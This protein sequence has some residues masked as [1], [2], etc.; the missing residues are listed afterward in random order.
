MLRNY[1]KISIRNLW[2]HKLLTSLNIFGLSLSMS[3]CLV[4][5]L[6]VRDH[7]QYDKFHPY[8][9]STYRITT[10]TRG[11]EGLFDEGYATS[12][13]PFMEILTENYSFVKSGTNLNSSF[14]GEIRS[15][16][17]I[18]DVN[19][20]FADEHFFDVFG[21]ELIEGDPEQ[22]LKEP[23]SLV[24]S[25][26]MAKKLFPEQS[27]LG[28]T[29]DF[30]DH[31]SY[32][33]TG[34][35]GPVD[36][37]T[38][39]KFEGLAS[40]STLPSL[41]EKE[42]KSDR[43]KSWDN[44]WHNYNYLVLNNPSDRLE[45]ERIINELGEENR[46]A[47]EDHPGYV[48]RLQALNEIVPGRTMSNEIGYALPWF[49]LAF[50]GLLGVIVLITASINYTN[51]SI[52]KSLGRAKEIGIRKVNGASKRQIVWQFLVESILTS[53][54]SLIVAVFI[55]RFLIT[56]F[57]ELWIFNIIGISIEDSLGAYGYFIIFTIMLGI[58]TGIGPA[59]FLSRLKTINSLK[60]S[61]GKTKTRRR[62][63][64]GRFSAKRMLI[65]VQFCLSILMLVTILIVKKQAHFLVDSNYGFDETEIFYVNTYDHDPSLVEQHFGGLS[66]VQEVSFTSHH[67]AIGRSHG[68]G[69][70]WKED[71]DPITLYNFSV[72]PNY[73]DV[74][75]LNLIAGK[76]FPK[77]ANYDIEKFIVL[78]EQAIETFGFE[79]SSQAIGEILTMDT[80][81]LTIIGVV[82]DYHWEPLM[83][84]IRPLALRIQPDRY[85]YSYLKV[86]GNDI[87]ASK[88]KF[89]D[90]WKD[91]DAAREFE[92]GFLNEQLDMTYQFF[93][94]LGNIL[95][96]VALIALSITGLGFLGMVSFDLKTR[97]K[98]IGIRKVLGAS[99]RSLT[100][101]M[102]KG[103][104]L[105]ILVSSLITVPFG[106][107]VN[108][109]W[110]YEMAFYAPLDTSIVLPTVMI[111][112]TIAGVTILSQVWVNSNKNPTE[113]LRAE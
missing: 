40:L 96:Y 3:V 81:S 61:L 29:V 92:G 111:I 36:Q 88:Q 21:F 32:K 17:K 63:I 25:H 84:S 109:L 23:Y 86:Q 51:L 71:Q 58:L 94:D 69:A 19:S 104:I 77:D 27:A 22:A 68:N 87:L 7:F 38:H 52:A 76:D 30:E 79:S 15:P 67:P 10:Y 9:D 5:I 47:D 75:G 72:D 100:Y 2:K 11:A 106:L 43:Y 102:S 64:I 65:G 13:L 4:L 78:N 39:M 85:E 31:G 34:V 1:L 26:D 83:N 66:G 50:F 16:Y 53:S 89:E 18:L 49:I 90:A 59:L 110:V 12:P 97:V 20:L 56:A 107:W 54:L 55:Y 99:F 46:E 24:L 60:G 57:N 113:T 73:I 28:Q 14:R 80:L 103:F 91:F 41:V 8:G 33:V 44:H 108:G 93:Y 105:L 42:V 82:K 95:T 37:N 45:V 112:L 74:M 98:E 101:S 62:S 48:F 6:L 70:K 35:V